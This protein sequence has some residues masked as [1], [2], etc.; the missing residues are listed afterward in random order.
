MV[1]ILRRKDLEVELRRLDPRISKKDDAFFAGLVL[2]S[3]LNVGADAEKISKF[4]GV[5]KDKILPLEKNLRKADVWVGERTVGDWFNKK[6]GGI[7]FWM[8]VCVALGM[9]TRK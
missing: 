3:G 4:L 5:P 6:N 7:A 2:L 9:L 1:K 8:D